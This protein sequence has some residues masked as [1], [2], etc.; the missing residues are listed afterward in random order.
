VNYLQLMIWSLCYG[1]GAGLGIAI[2]SVAADELRGYRRMQRFAAA[3]RTA[4]EQG[5]R[6]P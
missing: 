1:A 4:R 3:A 2:V 6:C 5:G